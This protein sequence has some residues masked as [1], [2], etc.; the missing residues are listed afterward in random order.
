MSEQTRKWITIMVLAAVVLLSGLAM[1]PFASLSAEPLDW[2]KFANVYLPVLN[3]DEDKGQPGSG[4]IFMA[5]GYPPNTDATVYVGVEARGIVT[6]DDNG[7]ATFAIQTA[8]NDP[9]GRYFITMAV[10]ANTSA[11]NDLRLESDRPLLILPPGF[12]Y[13]IFDLFGAIP[14]PTPTPSPTPVPTGNKVTVSTAS[15]GVTGDGVA[16]SA[17]DLITHDSGNWSWSMTFD[18]PGTINTDAFLKL[19]NGAYIVSFTTP[20]NIP[21]VGL[22]DD[23]DLLFY[24]PVGGTRQIAL[25]GSDIGLDT[26]DEDIDAVAIAPNGRLIISTTGDFSVP[27]NGGGT[28]TGSN[29]DLIQLHNAVFGSN[30]GGTWSIYFDGSDVGLDAHNIDAVWAG[31]TDMYVSVDT[32][33]NMGGISAEDNDVLA[34]L[35]VTTGG[36]SACGSFFILWDGNDAGLGTNSVD[37]LHIEWAAGAAAPTIRGLEALDR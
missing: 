17:G 28:L 22:L 15:G 25:D 33:L 4:F 12:P 3:I 31:G 6:T 7:Q 29:E 24:N 11:T 32:T 27:Q 19:N 8:N 30:S 20:V 35:S 34:C 14:T 18:V 36:T 1:M 26:D 37:A 13:P 10:D 16:Y 21:G 23:S 5:A 9:L 2:Q